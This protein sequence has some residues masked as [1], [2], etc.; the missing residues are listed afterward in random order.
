VTEI[1]AATRRALSHRRSG[2][3]ST[4]T[5]TIKNYYE[6][7]IPI[8][9]GCEGDGVTA[10]ETFPIRIRR[11]A[12]AQLQEF[13]RGWARMN[14]R[15]ASRYLVRKPDGDEQA[16]RP[17]GLTP[18]VSDEEVA[19]RRLAEMSAA[20]RAAYDQAV[21]E[22]QDFE[23]KFCAEA[24]A[25]HIWLPPGV[26]INVQHEDGT[27][28]T[29][30]DGAGLVSAFCGNYAM[31]VRL[32]RAIYEENVLSPEKKRQ[33]RRPFGSTPTLPTPAA[34]VAVDGATPAAIAAPVKPEVSAPSADVL[35]DPAPI[36]SGSDALVGTT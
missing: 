6:Q 16:F 24:I 4:K 34:A 18:I 29:A 35:Q 14:E 33:S 26:T 20:D 19:Q 13:Q 8:D 25:A 9:D 5:Y 7:N 21:K 1:D 10:G 12:V 17:N 11:F 36:P 31:L 28:V 3:M 32:V 22:D 30:S 15:R 27:E 2:L 23:A